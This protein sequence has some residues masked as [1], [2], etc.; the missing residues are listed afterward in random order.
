MVN[1]F[2]IKKDIQGVWLKVSPESK[3][4]DLILNGDFQ[5]ADPGLYNEMLELKKELQQ[6]IQ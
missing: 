2:T 1:K 5:A 6:K 4:L 3:L